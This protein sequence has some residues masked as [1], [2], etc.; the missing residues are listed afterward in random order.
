MHTC[1]CVHTS[2]FRGSTYAGVRWNTETFSATFASSGIVC[3]ADAPVPI[4]ATFLPFSVA[5]PSSPTKS[6]GQRAVWTTR[7]LNLSAP[8][9]CGQFG[10]VRPP[11]AK[12]A[13]VDLQDEETQTRTFILR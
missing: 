9:N 13:N 6:F 7:P 4:T 8:S 11:V 12:M 3:P 2:S 1:V 5:R 10:S